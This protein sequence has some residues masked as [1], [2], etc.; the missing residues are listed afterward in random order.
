MYFICDQ[1]P[2]HVKH[3]SF[4]MCYVQ[5][6]LTQLVEFIISL[7]NIYNFI[8]FIH[9]LH[10]YTYNQKYCHI[11]KGNICPLNLMNYSP[12]LFIYIL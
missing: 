9:T 3:K 1:F 4:C 5:R 2:C 11:T 8:I 7:K 6:S 10:L 12:F